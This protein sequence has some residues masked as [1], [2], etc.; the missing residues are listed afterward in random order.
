MPKLDARKK[1]PCRIKPFDATGLHPNKKL[2]V[3][4][5]PN[6]D[7]APPGVQNS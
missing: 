3:L 1:T 6:F 4:D 7:L 5:T 2:V